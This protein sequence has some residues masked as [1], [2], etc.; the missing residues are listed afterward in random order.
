M[1]TRRVVKW[2]AAVAALAVGTAVVSAQETSRPM[3]VST[4]PAIG[5]RDIDP[6]LAEISVTFDQDMGSGFSWTGGGEVYPETTGSPYWLDSRTCVLPVALQRGRFYRVGVNS[7]SHQNFRSVAGA[8]APPRVIHFC[9]QGA[10]AEELAWLTPPEVLEV[11]PADGATAVDPALPEI[12]ITFSQPMGGGRSLT[13]GGEKYPPFDESRELTWSDDRRTII[14]PVRLAPNHAYRF[15]INSFSHINF[16]S[17]R[18]VP[19]T[20]RRIQFQTGPGQ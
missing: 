10:P 13:G 15:G 18:G 20:P 7:R 1:K 17:E 14:W 12:R 11:V 3:I 19:V 5:A 6:A 16:M 8:P 9:T 4:N 2:Y